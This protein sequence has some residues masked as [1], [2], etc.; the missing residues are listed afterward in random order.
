[1]DLFSNKIIFIFLFNFSLLLYLKVNI[2]NLNVIY[3]CGSKIESKCDSSVNYSS[4][5]SFIKFIGYNKIKKKVLA[6]PNNV[7][8]TLCC[9]ADN[10]NTNY[11][12]KRKKIKT[13]FKFSLFIPK[14]I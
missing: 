6:L 11:L 5:I 2:S 13:V 1:M 12:A 10:C 4:E 3:G 7:Q 14:I 9:N 8:M